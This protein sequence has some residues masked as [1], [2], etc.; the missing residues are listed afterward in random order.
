[1]NV[2]QLTKIPQIVSALKEPFL[3]YTKLFINKNV[4]FIH[5][6]KNPLHKI[7]PNVTLNCNTFYNLN[8]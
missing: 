6:I 2:S 4:Y 8:I 1:M 7:V 3:Q 5:F